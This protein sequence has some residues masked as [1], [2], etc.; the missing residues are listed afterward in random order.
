MMIPCLSFV[1]IVQMASCNDEEFKAAYFSLIDDSKG[2]YA[3]EL[4]V[5]PS[6]GVRTL[7][8]IS[9]KDW[10]IVYDKMP[11]IDITPTSGHG[12]TTIF[13]TVTPNE[14]EEEDSIYISAI[15]NSLL[16]VDQLKLKRQSYL[17]TYK[18][19]A[20]I[21][22]PIE[23]ICTT[24]TVAD[25]PDITANA[26]LS[27]TDSK[28]ILLRFSVTFNLRTSYTM[29]LVFEGNMQPITENDNMK[30]IFH[31]VGTFD[32]T[33]L[34]EI[35]NDPTVTGVKNTVIDAELKGGLLSFQA[36]IDSETNGSIKP[37]VS[38]FIT[39]EGNR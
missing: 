7:T 32:L 30:F 29:N 15:N 36:T 38:T 1:W 24:C 17:A 37:G 19:S 6:G 9:N 11:W 39:F 26:V 4:L 21:S 27:Y 13:V 2:T 20:S 5:S 33:S 10:N 28:S 22:S 14:S 35:I 25:D 3:T 23:S 31:A 34:S 16:V 8:L 18:G 12:V